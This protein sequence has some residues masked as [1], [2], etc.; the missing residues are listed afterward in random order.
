MI[1]IIRIRGK[2]KLESSMEET[3]FR[4]RLRKKYTCVVLK[5]KP[6]IIGMLSKIRNC[7]AYGKIDA[8]TFALLI[9][10]RGQIIDKKKRIDGNKIAEEIKSEKIEKKLEDY[11]LKPYFRLHPPRGGI[12]SKKHFG[13]SR[14][15]VLGD[16]KDKINELIKRML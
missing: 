1:A 13:T 15:A 4:L 14:K 6:E 3:L 16:N 5:E 2:V 12:D 8:S 11:N 9:S 10:K 7:V